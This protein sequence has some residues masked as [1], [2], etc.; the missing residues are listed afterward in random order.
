MVDPYE[1][2]SESSAIDAAKTMTETKRQYKS[3]ITVP[4]FG[5]IPLH[6]SEMIA[7]LKVREHPPLWA[8]FFKYGVFGLLAS[9]VLLGVYYIART[10][11]GDYIADDLPREILKT[12]L[13]YV[14]FIGFVLANIVAYITNRMF[15][16]TP[17]VRHWTMEFLIFLV[18]SGVSFY[19]GNYA[20]DW[21]IDAGLNK[22]VAAL[23]FI[24][25][26]AL[27][28]FIARKYL[29]FDHSPKNIITD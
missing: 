19:A 17:S 26:S 10:F 15:V 28:N 29:V 21:F 14:M 7:D 5:E 9:G 22:D 3:S 18:V 27:V 24:V 4:V 8:Q 25:S 6:P 20:K 12:H 1:N 16:F 13:A 11:Y 2:T 23:S